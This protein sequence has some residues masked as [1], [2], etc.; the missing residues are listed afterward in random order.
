MR[1]EIFAIRYFLTLHPRSSSIHCV[2]VGNPL[3]SDNVAKMCFNP[4]KTFQIAKSGQGWY[5]SRHIQNFNSGTSPGTHWRGKIIGLADYT[6]NHGQH[7]IVI[8]LETGNPRDWFVGF[9]HKSG[10]NSEV[11]EAG[12]RVTIYQVAGTD[13]LG[14]STSSLKATLT[15][16]K[17]ARLSNWRNTGHNLLIK[18]HEI[19]TSD[20]PVGSATIAIEFGP[21]A[22]PT[23]PPTNKPTNL[24]TTLPPS[25]LP[26]PSPT[27]PPTSVPTPAPTNSVSSSL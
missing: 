21:Q 11:V 22:P 8:K 2:S 20:S 17:Q 12:N 16:G 24:P 13:G 3:W 10:V 4:V 14:Y 6:S 19:D 15:A 26:T 25:S 7:P 23:A 18:V 5:E 27:P 1:Y 9:N